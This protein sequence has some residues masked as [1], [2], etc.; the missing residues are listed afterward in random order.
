MKASGSHN[1]ENLPFSIITP[2]LAFQ[3]SSNELEKHK[4]SLDLGEALLTY[5]TGI[6][7]GEY[8]MYWEPNEAL[9]EGLYQHSK[10]MLSFGVYLSFLRNLSKLGEKSIIHS[11]FNEKQYPASSDFIFHWELLKQR[12]NEGCDRNFECEVDKL[13]KGRNV[14]KK[15]LIDFFS[16]FVEI[17]NLFAHPNHKAKNPRRDWPMNNEYYSFINTRINSV[18]EEIILNMNVL[19]KYVPALL[20]NIDES[21]KVANFSAETL[22]KREGIKQTLTE[23]DSS[24]LAPGN[25]YLMDRGH[26]AYVKVYNNEIPALNSVISEKI[27]S[28]VKAREGEK[29]VFEFIHDKLEDHIIDEVELMVLKETAKSYFITEERL[30]VMIDKVKDEKGLEGDI[31]RK[32]EVDSNISLA[33]PWWLIRLSSIQHFGRSNAIKEKSQTPEGQVLLF[34]DQHQLD[35]PVLHSEKFRG[36]QTERPTF[37]S[38][39]THTLMW[40]EIKNFLIGLMNKHLN[41]HMDDDDALSNRMKWVFKHNKVYQMGNMATYYWG[42]IYPETSPIEDCFQ[43]GFYANNKFKIG[44]IGKDSLLKK[45]EKIPTFFVFASRNVNKLKKVDPEGDYQKIFEE[46]NYELLMKDKDIF[47]NLNST[48]RDNP[49]GGIDIINNEMMTTAE[50]FKKYPNGHPSGRVSLFSSLYTLDDFL[51]DDGE[52]DIKNAYRISREIGVYFELFSYF[53]NKLTDVAL[54]RGF[55]FRSSRNL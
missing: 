50:F 21:A 3:K 15:G 8:K 4:V 18:L 13:K 29:I 1:C 43:I 19:S 39:N 54:S 41:K 46:F 32:K 20:E 53:I 14:A 55:N 17:R 38:L 10:R 42:Q 47:L 11:L 40:G 45:K 48:I 6:L 22:D 24:F 36:I 7:F 51:S 25:R 2:F 44:K 28:Q 49:Q 12:I 27:V 26:K 16:S 30:Y 5:L 31:F 37:L 52:L 34:S 35:F 33:S 9:E 23:E